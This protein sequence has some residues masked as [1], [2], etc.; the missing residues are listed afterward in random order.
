L[1]GVK[2]TAKLV[3]PPKTHPVISATASAKVDY[4]GNPDEF[5]NL[6]YTGIEVN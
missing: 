1:S 4:S 6:N 5:L 3:I 2:T